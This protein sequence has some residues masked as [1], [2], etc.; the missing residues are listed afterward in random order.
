MKTNTIVAALA[1]GAFIGLS[2]TPI[3][4][5]TRASLFGDTQRSADIL[6]VT[7][8]R[9]F[10]TLG[11]TPGCRSRSGECG[12][13]ESARV[14]V[15]TEGNSVKSVEFLYRASVGTIIG[16]GSEV[17]W[18]LSSATPGIH[19][20][21]VKARHAKSKT[22]YVTVRACPDCICDFFCPT[23]SVRGIEAN[24]EPGGIGNFV[25]DVSGSISVIYNW[26]VKGGRII[27]GKGTSRIAVKASGGNT[28]K[29]IA[30]VYLKNDELR[31][32]SC[33]QTLSAE[34]DVKRKTKTH[35]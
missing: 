35:F 10:V 2:A 3:L 13:P 29:V 31:T 17:I 30:T 7:L 24:V 12:H 28:S 19:S 1:L 8:D 33:V 27:S 26:K 11:C 18:D 15:T 16:S 23:V 21:M 34:I 5:V 14:Q 6:D 20:L 9:S 32:G 25:A 22:V 4:A